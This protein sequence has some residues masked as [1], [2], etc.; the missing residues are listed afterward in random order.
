MLQQV[1]ARRMLNTGG[2]FLDGKWR[3]LIQV[4]K[5]DAM[6]DQV[7]MSGGREQGGYCHV[8]WHL[9][10]VK[11]PNRS[12]RKMARIWLQWLE[13]LL[14][15]EVPFAGDSGWNA[16]ANVGIVSWQKAPLSGRQRWAG[17]G[18]QSPPQL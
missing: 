11:S 1:H 16:V 8:T 7:I 15:A 18:V 17:G 10:T 13:E 5:V 9:T 12:S 14:W 6:E 3:H 4:P 2:V